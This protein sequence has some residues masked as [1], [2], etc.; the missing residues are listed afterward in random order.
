[1]VEYLYSS[2]VKVIIVSGRDGACRPET[3]AWLDK[4]GIVYDDLHMRTPGDSRAD[5]VIKAEIFH[6]HIFPHYNVTGAFDDRFSVTN[7]LRRM[8]VDVF[9]VNHGRF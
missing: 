4:H 1:M 5:Y 9:A 6:E 2:D 3:E 7:S 8:G